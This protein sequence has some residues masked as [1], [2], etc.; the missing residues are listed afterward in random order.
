[1]PDLPESVEHILIKALA[2]DPKDR[3]KTMVEFTI[4]LDVIAKETYSGRKNKIPS[5]RRPSHSIG[6][7]T[8]E[9][10]LCKAPV[11]ESRIPQDIALPSLAHMPRP[12]LGTGDYGISV[13][14]HHSVSAR[15]R[16][17]KSICNMLVLVCLGLGTGGAPAGTLILNH[18]QS[19]SQVP[20]QVQ[21]EIST[22]TKESSN[23][24]VD[25]HAI[26]SPGYLKVRS[27]GI[28]K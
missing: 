4:A 13:S 2:K 17:W 20:T 22:S 27:R 11:P 8:A 25:T 10:P 24:V 12:V 21:S 6:Q 28:S 14:K 15:S 16:G 3:Y 26:P 1:V 9:P 23:I 5:N 18:P 7:T 19:S